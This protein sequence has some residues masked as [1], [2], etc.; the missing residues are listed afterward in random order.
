[1]LAWKRVIHAEN[2]RLKAEVDQLAAEKA[3]KEAAEKQRKLEECAKKNDDNQGADCTES[4]KPK[5]DQLPEKMLMEVGVFHRPLKGVLD[6]INIY[7]K[8][9]SA[10]YSDLVRLALLQRYGGTYVDA[11]SVPTTKDLRWQDTYFQ[12]RRRE[13]EI[14]LNTDATE[15]K[16][17]ENKLK[18][19]WNETEVFAF[20]RVVHNRDPSEDGEF[21]EMPVLESWFIAA[22]PKSQFM[23]LW[24]MEYQEMLA[25]GHKAQIRKLTSPFSPLAKELPDGDEIKRGGT[26]H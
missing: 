20:T 11:S 19:R 17:A 9:A 14:T 24:L 10:R 16:D 23:C 7:A 4:E 8:P 15:K 5:T 2:R 12:G 3:S 1:M 22:A 25:L 18:S 6:S 21:A 13:Q 26:T